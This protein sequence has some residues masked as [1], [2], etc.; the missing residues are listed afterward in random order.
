MTRWLYLLALLASLAGTL[1][2]DH[3]WRLFVFDRPR[4]ASL[5]LAIGV[6]F[7]TAWDLL[8]IGLGL[9][10]RG[11]GPY[12]SGVELAPHLP[13]E[14]LFFLLLLCESA[15]VAWVAAHRV[16]GRSSGGRRLAKGDPR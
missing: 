7:F 1:A 4:P 10:V 12:L 3:R 9:F 15:M 16:A 13:L 14:E 6:A 2:I 11:G 8:G 5:V